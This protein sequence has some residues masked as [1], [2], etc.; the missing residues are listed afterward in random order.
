MISIKNKDLLLLF[1]KLIRAVIFIILLVNHLKI[2]TI[3]LIILN[4]KD[5]CCS[6][7]NFNF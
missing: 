6:L 4:K 3:I 2:N 1:I 7:K 5:I